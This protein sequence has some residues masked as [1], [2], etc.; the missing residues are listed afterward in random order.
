MHEMTYRETE[1][2][3]PKYT[4]Y[5]LQLEKNWFLEFKQL[6]SLY[7]MTYPEDEEARI[8]YEFLVSPFV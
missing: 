1:F 7:K 5:G 8:P 6:W 2:Y 3:S 4:C